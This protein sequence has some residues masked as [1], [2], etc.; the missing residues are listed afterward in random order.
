MSPVDCWLLE[1]GYFPKHF[2][3]SPHYCA[4]DIWAGNCGGFSKL[5]FRDISLSGSDP[6]AVGIGVTLH[7]KGIGLFLPSMLALVLMYVSIYF[8]DVGVLGSFNSALKGWSTIT[9]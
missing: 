3:F 9:W 4:C 6:L 8:G 1:R 5:P 7:R 2:I